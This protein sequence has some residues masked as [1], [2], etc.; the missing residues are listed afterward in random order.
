MSPYEF[1]ELIESWQNGRTIVIFTQAKAVSS[2]EG[3]KTVITLQNSY[4][5]AAIINDF[6]YGLKNGGEGIIHYTLSLTE[7]RQ[8]TVKRLPQEYITR[9]ISFMSP[10]TTAPSGNWSPVVGAKA[11]VMAGTPVGNSAAKFGI[12]MPLPITSQGQ[13]VEI[14]N[15]Y[16]VKLAKIWWDNIGSTLSTLPALNA[17]KSFATM[18][19]PGATL[20]RELDLSK[21]RWVKVDKIV[22]P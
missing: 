10:L 9:D 11:K 3:T 8:Q 16:G 1:V 7:Y 15:M 2:K 14:A 17:I 6:E 22:K 20:L 4:S 13:I 21:Y 5:F 18:V 19:I 12:G